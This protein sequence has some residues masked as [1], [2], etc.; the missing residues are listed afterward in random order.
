MNHKNTAAWPLAEPPVR[1]ARWRPS[2][3]A[4]A[5]NTVA[6]QQSLHGNDTGTGPVTRGPP[7]ERRSCTQ[8]N[9]FHLVGI[10]VLHAM[11]CANP[12]RTEATNDG[13]VSPLPR[14]GD[15]GAKDDGAK[16]A[17]VSLFSLLSAA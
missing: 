1:R 13:I 6:N 8:L 12:A 2:S 11:F 4:A 5:T 7:T 10:C 16:H 15:D 9:F 3:F 17:R 14:Q